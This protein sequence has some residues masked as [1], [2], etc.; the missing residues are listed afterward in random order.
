MSIE[1]QSLRTLL[2]PFE[3]GQAV[4][5]DS[6][7]DEILPFAT[8]LPVEGAPMWVVGAMLWRVRRIPLVSL[9]RLLFDG[10]P[11]TGSRS[12]IAIVNTLGSDPNLSHFGVLTTAVPRLLILHP[13]ELQ[14]DDRG[15]AMRPGMLRRVR[16][17]EEDAIIL[18]LD[19][20]ERELAAVVARVRRPAAFS[21]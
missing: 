18:D 1:R 5:P 14:P 20:I 9:E 17:E 16:V 19:A 7:V 12:R 8:P 6:T 3:G 4:L 15:G 10:K 21:S 13:S 11:T 2:I